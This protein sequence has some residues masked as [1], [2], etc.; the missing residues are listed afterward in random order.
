MSAAALVLLVVPPV[1]VVVVLVSAAAAAAAAWVLAKALAPVSR[2]GSV[3][4]ALFTWVAKI[5]ARK[6]AVWGVAAVRHNLTTT[7]SNLHHTKKK[8][9]YMIS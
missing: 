5:F 1:V 2:S 3:K 8:G 7:L 9:Q 4:T 6:T